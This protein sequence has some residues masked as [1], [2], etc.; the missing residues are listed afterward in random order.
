MFNMSDPN[1]TQ[2]IIG[3]DPGTKNYAYS[4]IKV[5]PWITSK[6]STLKITP[7]KTGL[8]SN[9][10]T[11][12]QDIQKA[13]SA[14][15]MEVGMLFS[16][17]TYICDGIVVEQYQSRGSRNKLL[18]LVNLMLGGMITRYDYIPLSIFSAST[19]KRAIKKVFDLDGEYKRITCTPHEMDATL[20][21]IYGAFKIHKLKPYNG[22]SQAYLSKVVRKIEKV[23]TTELRNRRVKNGKSNP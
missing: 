21:G 15:L 11:S 9:T 3:L 6:G 13:L 2:I 7:L 12:L 22:Y 23:S 18:E 17:P 20:I 14:H 4:I 1:S 5:T 10:V 19:W 16:D 8:L